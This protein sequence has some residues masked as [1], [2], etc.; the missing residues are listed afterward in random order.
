MPRAPAKDRRQFI[1]GVTDVLD[2]ELEENL[3]HGC[4]PM[5]DRASMLR[6]R[7]EWVREWARWREVIL[8]K[9]IAHRPGRR[10]FAMYAVGEIPPRELSM[11]LPARHNYQSVVIPA[12]SGEPITHWLNVPEPYMRH[13]THH[14]RRLGIVDDDEWQRA[15]APRRDSYP[16]EMSLYE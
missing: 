13:E 4:V 8:P 9:C 10:P 15:R 16:L 11:P 2:W 1:E 3:L 6:T 12:A 5:I 7:G 14:L